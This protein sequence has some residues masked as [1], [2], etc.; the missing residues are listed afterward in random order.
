[1]RESK[2]SGL[3]TISAGVLTLSVVVMAAEWILLVAGVKRDEMIVGALS[4]IGATLFLQFVYR[5]EHQKLDL[6]LKDLAACWRIPWYIAVDVRVVTV[7]LLKDL[8]GIRRASS[9][10]RVCGFKTS[11]Y[12]PL[13]VSRR[14]LATAFTTVTP[15]AIVIGIDYE[16]SRMLFHQLQRSSVSKM[17]QEL[18]ALPGR[19][20]G[21]EPSPEPK[22]RS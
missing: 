22:G 1:M 4:V 14:V 17:T 18:G 5:A 10:Y 3:R 20:P 21:K 19:E 2:T 7:V 12:D 9:F 6:R 15:N 16:Q 13:L 11:K 8:L